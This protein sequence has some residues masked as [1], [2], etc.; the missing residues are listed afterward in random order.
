MISI[1][2]P[3]VGRSNTSSTHLHD[4]DRYFLLARLLFLSSAP[5]RPDV[6]RAPHL[7]P[8]LILGSLASMAHSI[9]QCHS[10]L[11]CRSG[12][13]GHCR[14]RLNSSYVEICAVGTWQKMDSGQYQCLAGTMVPLG[15]Q[16]AGTGAS[17]HT[18]SVASSSVA[19]RTQGQSASISTRPLVPLDDTTGYAHCLQVPL[20]KRVDQGGRA[21]Y[22]VGG[23]MASVYDASVDSSFRCNRAPPA[24]AYCSGRN[25]MRMKSASRSL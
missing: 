13:E 18:T 19:S 3:S 2:V 25:T 9:V 11:L 23:K 22:L 10:T 12:S 14:V 20:A 17:S 6:M 4:P 7:S 24:D 21:S 1:C 8:G 15:V 5:P 16:V